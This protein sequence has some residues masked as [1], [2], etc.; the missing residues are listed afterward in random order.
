MPR[1][2]RKVIGFGIDAVLEGNRWEWS[3]GEF[4]WSAV[5]KFSGGL[6]VFLIYQGQRS[7]RLHFR[8]L[9]AAGM[10][11]EG[12]AEGFDSARRSLLD[13]PS[14]GAGAK[15]PDTSAAGPIGADI[16]SLGKIV[17]EADGLGGG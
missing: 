13:A 4:R 5:Q 9:A 3:T 11:A 14:S 8:D 12:F 7:L 10:F 6:E 2:K 1:M 17:G 16:P 15:N